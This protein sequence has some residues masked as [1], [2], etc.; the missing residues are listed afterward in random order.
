MSTND[1]DTDRSAAPVVESAE[2]TTADGPTLPAPG[3]G[4][5]HPVPTTAVEPGADVHRCPYCDRPF[6]TIRLKTLHVGEVHEADATDEEQAVFE[7]ARDLESDD[8][9]FF[10]IKI[11]IALGALYSMSVIGYTVVI[12]LL[13]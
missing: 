10:H 9:F 7:K 13:G 11:V 8:L 12:G 4:P 1:P 6:R 5:S 2:L 3:V